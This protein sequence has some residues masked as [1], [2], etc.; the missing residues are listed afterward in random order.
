MTTPTIAELIA[1]HEQGA[2][3]CMDNARDAED[4]GFEQEC[5]DYLLESSAMHRATVDAL[6]AQEAV[7]YLVAND[8]VFA[9]SGGVPLEAVTWAAVVNDTF[10]YAAADAEEITLAEAVEV[11]DDIR[12]RFPS[13]PWVAVALWAQRKRGGEPFIPPVQEAVDKAL[14]RLR[15]AVNGGNDAE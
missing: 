3:D 10:A 6:K 11:Y 14:T 1:W 8:L 5:I 9:T 2:R 12:A 15:A 7:L 13:K 4:R